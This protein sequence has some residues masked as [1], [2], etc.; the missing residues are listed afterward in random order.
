MLK[1][2]N[3]SN[4]NCKNKSRNQNFKGAKNVLFSTL[5]KG[6]KPLDTFIKMQENLSST[7]FVQ[8]TAT[9]WAPKALFTRSKADLAEMS[10]LEFLESAIFYFA[11]GLIG[12]N[13]LRKALTKKLPK[14]LKQHVAKTATNILSDKKLVESGASKKLLPVKAGILLGCTCI[15]AAEYA[16]SFA[17]NLFTLKVFKTADFKDIANLDKNKN[18]KSAESEEHKIKVKNSA[19]SHIAG[20]IGVSLAGLIGGITLAKKGGDSDVLQKISKNILEPG[21]YLA[22]KLPKN[23]KYTQKLGNFLKDYVNLDFDSNKGKLALS[24]GQLAATAITGFFGYYSAAKD[25]DPLDK[26][27]VLTRVPLVVFYT[28]FGSSLFENGFKHL[29]YKKNAFPNLIKKTPD[30]ILKVPT[31]E[32]LPEIA[33]NLAKKLKDTTPEAEF[34]KLVKGKAVI[35]AIPFMFSLLFMGLSLSAINRVWTQYRYNKINAKQDNQPARNSITPK[36]FSVFD[37]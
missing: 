7:R 19:K 31:R 18:K 9:N 14:D 1:V 2:Q 5:D 34:K 30:N 17:K 27:E 11:P 10:F 4:Q 13:I 28:I 6:L 32:E 15:P 23:K 33:N 16:L 12:E 37:K 21:S 24:K 8:D 20:A 25:R 26:L 22:D 36:V 3:I 35:T 29:L